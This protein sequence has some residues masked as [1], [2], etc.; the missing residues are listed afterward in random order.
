MVAYILLEDSG[1]QEICGPP[2]REMNGVSSVTFAR[3]P[4]SSSKDGWMDVEPEISEQYVGAG[5]TSSNIIRYNNLN[6]AFAI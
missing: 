5:L 2:R 3:T 1:D 4:D 6:C